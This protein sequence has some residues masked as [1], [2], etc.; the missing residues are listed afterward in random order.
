[1]SSQENYPESLGSQDS[2]SSSSD[3]CYESSFIDDSSQDSFM[4]SSL[5]F[6]ETC[7]DCKD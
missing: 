5:D 2:F 6:S 1:M 4:S 3:G 7:S